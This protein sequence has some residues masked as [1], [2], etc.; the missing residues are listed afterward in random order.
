MAKEKSSLSQNKQELK[1]HPSET[2]A[3]T[4]KSEARA[5]ANKQ[6][7]KMS[8]LPMIIEYTEDLSE[9][10][11]PQPLPA[12]DYT[13]EIRGVEAKTSDKGNRY[14]SVAFFIEP[15]QYPADY[16][17]GNPDGTTMSYNRLSPEANQR[18]RWNMKKFCEAIGVP[19]TSKID[20]N[21]WIGKTAII[22]VINGSYEGSPTAQ[23]KKIKEA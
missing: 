1:E 2:K 18:A 5:D 8:E 4:P 7:N 20:L 23:I 19:L 14:I 3:S 12:G 9:A 10:T 11:E 13:G 6:G 17:D 21:E 15:E 16:T 22:E